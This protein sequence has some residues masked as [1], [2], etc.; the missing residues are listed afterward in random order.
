MTRALITGAN[1]GIGLALTRALMERGVFVYAGT[2]VPE[3]A[4]AL[5]ELRAARADRLEVVALDVTKLESVQHLVAVLERAEGALDILVNNAGVLLEE[6]ETPIEALDVDLFDRTFAV[7]V[8]GVARVTQ[9]VLPWLLRSAS[10]RIVNIS[11]GAG[12]LANKSDH[13]YTCYGAS[14]A[15]LNHVTLGLAHQLR[16]RGVT[17]VALSP[18]WVRT[19][20]G[21]P[22]AE[23]APDEVGA[24][25]AQTALELDLSR[26]GCFL[27]RFGRRGRYVW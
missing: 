20:M 14:K 19:D 15:A 16:P 26:N 1:R 3:E 9:A 24:S 12:S 4:R 23:L 7:N 18:G 11:S 6:I 2:R 25:I 13:H 17:V 21:G 5:Q 8:V 22:E 27:D 10:P